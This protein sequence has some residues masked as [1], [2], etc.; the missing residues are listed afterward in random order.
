MAHGIAIGKERTKL[1]ESLKPQASQIQHLIDYGSEDEMSG[2]VDNEDDSEVVLVICLWGK[3]PVKSGLG[4]F[5][6]DSSKVA[7]YEK[8]EKG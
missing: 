5:L 2:S 1:K 8:R 4:L 3:T 7:A 6:L